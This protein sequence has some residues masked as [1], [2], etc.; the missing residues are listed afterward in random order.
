MSQ[1]RN[2]KSPIEE[3]QNDY[4]NGDNF[5]FH[6]VLKYHD[7]HSEEHKNKIDLLALEGKAIRAYDSVNSGY[8]RDEELGMTAYD[9]DIFYARIYTG[10]LVDY[11]NGVDEEPYIKLYSG[12]LEEHKQVD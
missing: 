4:N 3:M 12:Y 10:E 11:I 9:H 1:L 2:N 7:M 5:V 8:N 6:V